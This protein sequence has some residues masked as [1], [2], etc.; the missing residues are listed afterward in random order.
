MPSKARSLENNP[1]LSLQIGDSRIFRG[2]FDFLLSRAYFTENEANLLILTFSLNL[3]YASHINVLR[4]N[5]C[6]VLP[7]YKTA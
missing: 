7:R 4:F 5:Y 3:P 6:N 1:N 2:I